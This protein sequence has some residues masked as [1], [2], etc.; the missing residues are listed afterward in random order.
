MVKSIYSI[1]RNLPVDKIWDTPRIG[2][3]SLTILEVDKVA[4]TISILQEASTKHLEAE[5][6]L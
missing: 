2:N 1:A 4:R 6:V 5:P 3:T